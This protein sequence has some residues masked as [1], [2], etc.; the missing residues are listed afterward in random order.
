MM[1]PFPDIALTVDHVCSTGNAEDGYRIATR[2][3]MMG[4]HSGQGIYGK[5]TGKRIRIMG[6]SHQ[7]L[8]Q[9]KMVQEWRLFD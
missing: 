7:L 2:W 1:S 6:T 9:E 4:T 5:P 8:K 3:T